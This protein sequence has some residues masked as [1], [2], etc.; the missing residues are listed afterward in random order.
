MIALFSASKAGPA[1]LAAAGLAA[2]QTG[3]AL[4]AGD[5]MAAPLGGLTIML[6][7][8]AYLG[9]RRTLAAIERAAGAADAAAKGEL[10]AR[11]RGIREDGS[12]GRLLWNINRLL[13]ITEAFCKEA[14]A[15][16]QH[17]NERKYYRSIIATGLRGDFARH[18]RTINQSLAQM[19]RRDEEALA[20]AEETVQTLVSSVTAAAAQ[21]QSNVTRLAAN[22]SEALDQATTAA[23]DADGMSSN[24]QAV[25]AA[26]E[27]L[28]ASFCE[29]TNQANRANHITNE[30]A[31]AAR[32]TDGT[33]R[34]LSEAAD[35][36]GDVLK[37]IGDIAA[38]TNLLALNATIEAARAGEAGKGF[39]VVA[40]EIKALANQTARATE[41]IATQIGQMQQACRATVDAIERIGKTV[42]H[43]TETSTVV[44]GAVEEQTAVTQEIT[45]NVGGAALGTASVSEAIATVRG[46]VAATS[47]QAGEMTAA[48]DHLFARSAALQEHLHSFIGSIR[49][50]A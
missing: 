2:L 20:F 31:A 19:L 10:T 45:R 26:V 8:G 18:A 16:M 15:A 34:G 42:T 49:S 6:M 44:A 39:A 9:A 28:S 24:V 7:T 5:W 29:I 37:L 35:R 50:A 13:D 27:E 47:A 12:L 40:G 32:A 21:L 46:A 33:V 36:I 11:I 14:D 23:S 41:E 30:A 22:M 4:A 38:Q 17:A 3:W 43:I 1:C 48:V 25:A